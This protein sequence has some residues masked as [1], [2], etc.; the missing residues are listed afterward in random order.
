M[1][2]I[3]LRDYGKQPSTYGANLNSHGIGIITFDYRYYARSSLLARVTTPVA[4]P[5]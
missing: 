3:L 2:L 5:S 4:V 1:S